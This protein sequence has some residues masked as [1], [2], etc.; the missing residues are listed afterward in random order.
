MNLEEIE[1]AM[2]EYD[3]SEDLVIQIDRL[4]LWRTEI[5]ERLDKISKLEPPDTWLSGPL[6]ISFE[7][8]M[9]IKEVCGIA[10]DELRKAWA[11]CDETL[12]ALCAKG[13]AK[14][15]DDFWRERDGFM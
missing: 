5:L 8:L 9:V 3:T 14:K 12:E 10:A 2:K 1:R 11:D 6:K 15:M 4:T 13:P 7:L